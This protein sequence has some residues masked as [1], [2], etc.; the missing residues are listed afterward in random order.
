[1]LTQ[2]IIHGRSQWPHMS[3][4]MVA[5]GSSRSTMAKVV[6]LGRHLVKAE[7]AVNMDECRSAQLHNT[8]VCK[9]KHATR[10]ATVRLKHY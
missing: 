1:M 5:I 8:P 3:H 7:A 2:G 4:R 9:G 6:L 10:F